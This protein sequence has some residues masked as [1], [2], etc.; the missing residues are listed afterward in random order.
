MTVLLEIARVAAAVNILLLLM[1]GYVW[2]G[3]YRRH[4]AGHTQGLLI[5]TAFLLVQNALWLYLYLFDP[6]FIRWFGRGDLTFQL[7]ITGLCGLQTF[8]LL[9]LVRITWK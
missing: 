6:Q 9:A 8:A 1:L 5:F 4:G 2:G 3:N 7:S